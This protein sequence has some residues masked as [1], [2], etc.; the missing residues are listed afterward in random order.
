MDYFMMAVVILSL[1]LPD[2]DSVQTPVFQR[3]KN[4]KSAKWLLLTLHWKEGKQHPEN[5]IQERY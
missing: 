3:N 2:I 5:K 1:I 4:M